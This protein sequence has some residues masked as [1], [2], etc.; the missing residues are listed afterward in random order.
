MITLIRA[1]VPLAAM[2]YPLVC[3]FA[4]RNE[5]ALRSAHD[6]IMNAHA[7]LQVKQTRDTIYT[8]QKRLVVSFKW[9]D[10]IYNEH[11]LSKVKV[12]A[13][14]PTYSVVPKVIDSDKTLRDFGITSQA[15]PF[16]PYFRVRSKTHS[17][18]LPVR[19]LPSIGTPCPDTTSNGILLSGRAETQIDSTN[20]A[21]NFN[22]LMLT[23]TR[24]GVE[25]R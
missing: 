21:Q 17:S 6:S 8:S 18:S 23:M 2:E 20:E 19:H 12:L 14:K 25:Q 4:L 10:F 7:E 3:E 1:S 9:G 15:I 11:V 24:P 5:L 16:D 22:T 13:P